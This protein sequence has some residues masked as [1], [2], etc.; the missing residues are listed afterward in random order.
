MDLSKK[1]ILV[2]TDGSEGMLSQVVGLAQEISENINSIKTRIIF[3]WSKL[4]PGLLPIFSWIFL[5]DLN[6]ANKP[7]I[8]I[9][10]GRKSVFLSIF[11][12]KKYKKIINIHIQNPKANFKYFNFIVPPLHD[13]I[14]GKNVIESNG[15]LHR[16]NKKILTQINDKNFNITKDKLVSVIIGGDNNHYSFGKKE[17]NKLAKKIIKLKQQNCKFNFLIITSRRTNED[18]KKNLKNSLKNI[19]IVWE[20]LNN[21]PYIFALKYSS[22]FIVSSDS[23]SMISECSITEKP[24]YV[25][26]LPFKRK[27]TRME[28]FHDHFEKMNITKK[29]TDLGELI[30]WSYQSLNESKR[31]AGI[32]KKR[33]IKEINES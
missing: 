14:N 2:I 31:I 7:D 8:I 23:T 32:I 33:I 25:F 28:K 18:M 5:N 10:C 16:F 15:A 19:E 21:N 4:Q 17:I 27:S 1:N 20:D 29:L 12:K 9:S 30:P 11:L 6:F 3:P 26:H 22:F 24:I 13:N